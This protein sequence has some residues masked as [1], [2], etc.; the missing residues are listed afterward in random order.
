MNNVREP[1]CHSM[2]ERSARSLGWSS[3]RSHHVSS[4]SSVE[5]LAG[6][7]RKGHQ[8]W[9]KSRYVRMQNAQARTARP[10]LELTML[11]LNKKPTPPPT[12]PLPP[13]ITRRAREL[14][15]K[16]RAEEKAAVAATGSSPRARPARRLLFQEVEQMLALRPGDRDFD[17]IVRACERCALIGKLD[18]ER[19][20]LQMKWG[21]EN[22]ATLGT[23][24]RAQLHAVL[25]PVRRDKIGRANRRAKRACQ[26]AQRE[27]TIAAAFARLPTGVTP[28][29]TSCFTPP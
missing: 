1:S 6:Q 11:D 23:E 2:R 13:L 15:A 28:C 14:K 3:D 12:P 22:R 16:Q 25:L 7:I 19:M 20:T 8:A 10:Q 4:Q 5:T 9:R 29:F 18:I 26:S 17:E 24:L 27:L 21:R